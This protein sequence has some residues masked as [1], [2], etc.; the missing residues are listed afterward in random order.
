MLNPERVELVRLRLGLTK[1]GFAK[2][3]GV[4]RKTLQRFESGDH[5]LND[6]CIAKL[7]SASKYPKEFFEKDS[8]P[9]YPGAEAVSFRS[10]RSL[11]AAPRNAALAAGALAFELDDWIAQRYE[12]PEHSLPKAN[13]RDPVDAALAVRARWGIGER[14]IGNMINML[15]SHGVRVFSLS[16]ETR[17]LDAYSFWREGRPYVFLNTM[18]TAEHSRYDSA[19]ELGHLILHAHGGPTSRNAEDEANAF[20]SAFLMPPADLRAN[21]PFV[22]RFEDLVK[23]KKRWGVSVAALAYALHKQGIISDWHYRGYCIEINKSG[24]ANEPDG[25]EPETSQVW[26]KILTDLWRQGISLTHIARELSI[27]EHELSNLLF[28]I[29]RA[30]SAVPKG[31]PALSVV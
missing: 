13:N 5:D 7:L 27:P 11:T 26:Q 16:E 4:D 30:P 3:L 20:A 24:R 29:A 28:G 22:R 23:G 10:L 15:E 6:E 8:T 17:H 2:L 14:P 21:V 9:K 31:R 1:I 19:H 18:K 12:V 25:M